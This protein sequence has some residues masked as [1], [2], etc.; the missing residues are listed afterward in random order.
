MNVSIECHKFI[1]GNGVFLY[2]IECVIQYWALFTSWMEKNVCFHDRTTLGPPLTHSIDVHRV[3][4]IKFRECQQFSIAFTYF[5]HFQKD[6]MKTITRRLNM[7]E[8]LALQME[9]LALEKNATGMVC[10]WI[11]FKYYCLIIETAITCRTYCA[12]LTVII[13]K[14]YECFPW[15]HKT[16]LYY[17]SIEKQAHSPPP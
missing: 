10:G 2:C 1:A 7:L 14:F 16:W 17:F 5:A 11:P 15:R 6:Q 8:L 3:L 9:R 13:M 12:K 4:W